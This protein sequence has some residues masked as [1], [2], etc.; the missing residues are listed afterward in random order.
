M[1]AS[2]SSLTLLLLAA[3]AALG[4]LPCHSQVSPQFDACAEKDQT[5]T[6]LDRCAS[7]EAQRADAA[8]NDAYRQLRSMARKISGATAKVERLERA[9][10]LYRD[11]Y[12]AAMFPADDKQVAY[13]TEFP[14][15]FDL[16][17]AD[18]TREQTKKVNELIKQY[19]EEGQ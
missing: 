4:V 8:L 2:I 9:W 7:D 16:L 17:R 15:D 6:G 19:N 1:R 10:I 11:T 18:L 5:Q 14:M 3:F 13:G 12:L